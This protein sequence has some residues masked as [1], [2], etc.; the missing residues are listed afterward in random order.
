MVASDQAFKK[1][2]SKVKTSPF[3]VESTLER[4]KMSGKC[5]PSPFRPIP[6]GCWQGLCISERKSLH[7]ET[8][9]VQA[10]QPKG[11]HRKHGEPDFF[12]LTTTLF[13]Y[14]IPQLSHDTPMSGSSKL[15]FSQASRND[16]AKQSTKWRS[17]LKPRLITSLTFEL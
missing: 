3:F 11:K 16:A 13:S 2:S 12:H 4:W 5:Q 1:C 14:H 15:S 6:I 7:K 10:A 9:K 8:C 17:Q